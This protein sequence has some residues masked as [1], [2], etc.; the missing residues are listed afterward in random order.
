MGV[1]MHPEEQPQMRLAQLGKE[2]QKKNDE[3]LAKLSAS[4]Q[5]LVDSLK[6]GGNGSR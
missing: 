2:R 1:L 5:A 4:V 6:S 3:Q